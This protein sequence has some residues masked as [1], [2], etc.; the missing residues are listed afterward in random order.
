MRA[1]SPRAVLPPWAPALPRGVGVALDLASAT[2]IAVV[3]AL[4]LLT[5]RD[6][7]I[8]WDE[9]WH[10][11]Y[12]DFILSWITTLGEDGSALCY[13]FDYL[14][15][16]AFDLLGALLRRVSP[17]PPYDTIHLLGALVGV[18]GL[19]GTWSLARRLGGPLAGLAA[20]LLLATTPSYYGHMFSNPK[21]L[22]FAVGYV[23]ALDALVEVVLRLPRVPRRAWLRFSIVAG[24]TMGVRVGGILLLV[25]L[26]AVVV[27]SAVLRARATGSL[28]AGIDTARR[29]GRPALAAMAGAWVVMLSTWPWALLDPMRRPFMALGRMSRFVMHRRTMPFAGEEM[30]TTDPRWDY[31]LHY[32]GLKL[33]LLLLALVLVAAALCLLALR[34]SLHARLPKAK[35]DVALVLALAIVAPPTYAVVV[36]SVLYDGLRHFLFLVPP[37][38]A[39]AAVALVLI[40]RLLPR[41]SLVVAI[42]LALLT[43]GALCRQVWQM[44]AL[45]PYQYVYFNELEGGLPGAFG[46]Y[47]TDYYGASYKEGFRVLSEHL[48][49][50]DHEAYLN[51]RYAVTG[52]IPDFIAVEYVDGNLAWIERGHKGAQ[53]YLG[54]TRSNCDQRHRNRPVMLEV[55]R[56]STMLLVIRDMRRPPKAD[57]DQPNPA[58]GEAGEEADDEDEGAEDE[59]G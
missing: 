37:M 25:Y 29:L 46:S 38:A 11:N 5:F 7:G 10:L 18:L 50:T 56:E 43:A 58:D 28:D 54:Y 3:L 16:G 45:H 53:F 49:Q 40:P 19:L 55:E 34:P 17:L 48:W 30:L 23:W 22:P 52:C 47:D 4:V 57:A 31:L 39:V 20:V 13:K 8:T 1:A 42:G 36:R 12:G 21:D 51:N 59:A 9:T 35:R 14:Y 2:A 15:G 41:R 6:Y 44:R 26:G 33:P 32:F 24:L 27:G